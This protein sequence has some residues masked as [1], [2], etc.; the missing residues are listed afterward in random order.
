MNKTVKY[1]LIA[2]AS[3][4]LLV[5][6]G[7]LA[8]VLLVDVERYKPKIEQLVTEK[9]GY[10]LTLGGEIELSIFPWIGLSFTDLQLDNPD[11]FVNKN[12]VHVED[13]QARLKVVPLL[14]R[15]VEISKFVVKEPRIYLEKN[16]KGIW[17]WQKLTEIGAKAPSSEPTAT[18]DSS[19]TGETGGFVLESLVVEEFSITDGRVVIDDLENKIKHEVSGFNLQLDD[20]ALDTPVKVSLLAQLDGK[21]LSLNGTVGPV[22]ADPGSGKLNLDLVIEAL[23]NLNIQTSGY[24]EDIKGQMKYNLDLNVESFSPKQLYSSLGMTFPVTTTDSDA[25]ENVSMQAHVAGDTKQAVLSEAIVLLDDTSIALDVTAKDFAKPDLAI[26]MAVDAIDLDRYL[27]PSG[28]EKQPVPGKSTAEPVGKPGSKETAGTSGGASSSK[29]A[30]GQTAKA[31]TGIDYEPLR[32]LVLQANVKVGEMKAHGGTLNNLALDLAGRNGIFTINS[33]GTEL[34]EGNIAATGNLNVQKNVPASALDLVL[35][36]VQVGPLLKDFANKEVIEGMLK[37]EIGV[38]MKGD[39]ANRIKQSLN[40]KGNLVFKDGALIGLDLA[41]MARNIKSGFT[42]E[43]QGERPKTDFAELHAPFT[44]TNGVVNT[45]ETTMRSPFIRVTVSGDANLVNEALDLKVK[46]TL[47]GTIKGQ[48]DEAQR[49]GLTIP[50][51]VGGTF[52]SPKFTADLESF[53]KEQI[54]TEEEL[55]EIIKSGKIPTERKEK[56]EKEVEEAKGLLKGLF[57]N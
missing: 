32:K 46:P 29:A 18:S 19:G 55:G 48:G 44:I 50:V 34:Y 43:E 33:F 27:P 10:P 28:A 41:Q 53:V 21:P 7:V 12:F 15:K 22:G 35:Q 4:G 31:E 2:A 39:N 25:L 54:P 47:V 45:P 51:L 17:N 5:I 24:L 13:F 20:V 1:F 38:S 37:A 49:S 8:I 56:F 42:L 11:G 57:G 9:T 16:S 3:L 36:N 26:N 6:V 23:D 40:G 52:N 14:S 30:A